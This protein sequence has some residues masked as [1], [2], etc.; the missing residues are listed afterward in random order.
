MFVAP[1]RIPRAAAQVADDLSREPIT[2]PS[3]MGVPFGTGP[4]GPASG[5]IDTIG[6]KLP[7]PP[8]TP[9]TRKTEQPAAP[10]LQGGRVQAAKLIR[11]VIPQYPPL[12]RQARISGTVRLQGLIA[13]D[14][15]IK[16]LQLISGHPLLVRAALDAVRQ[17]V[18]RP[19]TLNGETVEV[20]APIDVVFTLNQ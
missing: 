20:A 6:A 12:A 15:T 14:G 2:P 17:W 11:Q 19:T 18:Y 16:D 13:K 4:L 10:L 7:A 1:P 5:L 3:G 9:V 8:P